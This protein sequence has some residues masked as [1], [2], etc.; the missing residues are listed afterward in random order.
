MF[1]KISIVAIA[2]AFA[3]TLVACTPTQVTSK[4]AAVQEKVGAVCNFIPTVGT[5]AAILA[6][7]PGATA[8]AVATAI[9]AAVSNKSVSRDAQCKGVVKGVCVQ[10]RWVR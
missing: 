8:V 10:G 1:K 3:L 5:V 2:A 7:A 6:G 4:I 9:C